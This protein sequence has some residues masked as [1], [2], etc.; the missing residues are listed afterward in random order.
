MQLYKF[1]RTTTLVKD[2]QASSP[3]DMVRENK[4]SG[5]HSLVLLDIGMEADDGIKALIKNK[6]ILENE[7]IIACSNLGTNKAEI[8]Y[9]EAGKIKAKPMPAVIIVPG[10]LNFKEEEALGLWK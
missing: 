1:G 10:K 6:V 3:Y 8:K 9:G 4:K 2:F 5:L 7:K